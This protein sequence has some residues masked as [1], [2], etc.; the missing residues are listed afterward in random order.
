M[1]KMEELNKKYPERRHK[2]NTLIIDWHGLEAKDTPLTDSDRVCLG[3]ITVNPSGE[4]RVM[5]DMK[6]MTD[7]FPEKDKVILQKRIEG[8]TEQETAY[9]INKARRTVIRRLN[10][11]F[12]S[13]K[14]ILK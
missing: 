11:L 9:F 8:W 7:K 1:S 2:R 3:G 12:G 14:K 10:R 5:L 13:L 6:L 4:I